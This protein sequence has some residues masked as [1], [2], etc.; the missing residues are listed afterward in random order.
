M[1]EQDAA[2]HRASKPR[3]GPLDTFIKI[4]NGPRKRLPAPGQPWGDGM[5]FDGIDILSF[6]NRPEVRPGSKWHMSSRNTD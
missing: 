3:W 4:N 1:T 5:F 6:S 2:F